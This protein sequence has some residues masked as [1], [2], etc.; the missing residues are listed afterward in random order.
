VFTRAQY[1]SLMS[2]LVKMEYIRPSAGN[3]ARSLNQKGLALMKAL[4]ESG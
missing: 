3:L 2:E 1:D 4:A